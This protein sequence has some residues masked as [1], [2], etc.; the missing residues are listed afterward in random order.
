MKTRLSHAARSA[1]VSTLAIAAALPG[2]AHGALIEYEGSPHGLF[3][4][5]KARLTRDL[6]AFLAD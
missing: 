5:D 1:F 3:A 6:L 2:L 4:T